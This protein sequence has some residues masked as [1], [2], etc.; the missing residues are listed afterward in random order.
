MG[1]SEVQNYFPVR[2]R[3]PFSWV[4][5]SGQNYKP[6]RREHLIFSWE[7]VE[8]IRDASVSL[9]NELG[10]FEFPELILASGFSLHL[11]LPLANMSSFLLLTSPTVYKS[12]RLR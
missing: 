12:Q 5:D 4:I 10:E 7:T 6:S 9:Q 8:P 2:S 1:M 11:I 3:N